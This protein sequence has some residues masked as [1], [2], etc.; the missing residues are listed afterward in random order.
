MGRAL[1]LPRR[2][3]GEDTKL[4]PGYPRPSFQGEEKWSLAGAGLW[5]LQPALCRLLS[6][7]PCL[8]MGLWLSSEGGPASGMNAAHSAER[9][10]AWGWAPLFSTQGHVIQMR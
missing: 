10:R 1:C 6:S 2:S 7:E 8:P 4:G 5:A 9:T 3:L